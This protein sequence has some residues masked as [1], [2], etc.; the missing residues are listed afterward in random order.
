MEFYVTGE[1]D[2]E[3]N[4]RVLRDQ[5]AIQRVNE[6][7]VERRRKGERRFADS[8]PHKDIS[9]ILFREFHISCEMLFKVEQGYM[10]NVSSSLIQFSCLITILSR[11][12]ILVL[13]PKL[14]CVIGHTYKKKKTLKD[15]FIG[16]ISDVDVQ[17]KLIKA[18]TDLDNTPKLAL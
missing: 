13:V 4:A 7:N 1:D 11:H 5:A 18:K 15:L 3:L 2:G 14:P 17:Q 6:L 8:F 9:N 10:V 16:R 12:F